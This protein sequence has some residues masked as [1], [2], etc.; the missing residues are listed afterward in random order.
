M[1]AFVK[2]IR[3]AN[4]RHQ[5]LQIRFENLRIHS[6]TLFFLFATDPTLNL[7]PLDVINHGKEFGL[8]GLSEWPLHTAEEV[9]NLIDCLDQ[10]Y[11]NDFDRV[12]FLFTL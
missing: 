6:K 2:S 3:V 1:C 10:Q 4:P 11:C 12:I 7:F 8:I 9:H 5:M